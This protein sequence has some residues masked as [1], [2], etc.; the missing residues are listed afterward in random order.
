MSR[1]DNLLIVGSPE[2]NKAMEAELSRLSRR[3]LGRV[4]ARAGR[5]GSGTLIYPFDPALARVALRYHRTSSRVLAELYRCRAERLEPLYDEVH[6]AVQADD[7]DWLRDGMG[8]SVRARNIATFAAGERQIVGTIKNA[9]IDAAR[10]RGWQVELEPDHPDLLV[11]ARM[12]D[13]ELSISL[14]LGEGS[15]SQRGYRREA[16]EAPLREHLAAVLLM[17]ARWD[18]RREVLLDPMCGSGTIAI[19]AALMARAEPRL[20]ASALARVPLVG[21]GT[22]ASGGP[23]FADATAHILASDV[24]AALIEV[25]RSNAAAAGVADRVSLEVADAH[26]LTPGEVARALGPTAPRT[27]LILSNP[28]YGERLRTWE[29]E[30]LYERLGRA[31]RRFQGWRA[32]FI[33]ASDVFVPAFGGKPRVVKPLANGPLRGQFLLYDL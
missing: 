28:P 12:H 19:E 31:C 22:E 2:T 16:G 15:L 26:E 8:I 32:A 27:G 14:D 23:L 3:A 20:P 9:I 30:E 13:R 33:V 24:D 11:T 6:A 1:V 25:A 29:L 21:A 10:A 18:S 4:P 7:R 5:A 17:L